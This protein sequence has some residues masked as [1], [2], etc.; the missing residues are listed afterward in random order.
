M[1]LRTVQEKILPLTWEGREFL[2]LQAES[3]IRM[4]ILVPGSLFLTHCSLRRWEPYTITRL[5]GSYVSWSICPGAV[6]L[7]YDV[8]NTG[9]VLWLMLPQTM[10]Q[11]LCSG[12][13]GGDRSHNLTSV[14]NC[15]LPHRPTPVLVVTELTY[16]GRKKDLEPDTKFSLNAAELLEIW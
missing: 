16:L 13:C 5:S 6:L 1:G 9:H 10:W 14:S 8:G 2:N 7:S 4:N 12:S 3:R 11:R 15:T